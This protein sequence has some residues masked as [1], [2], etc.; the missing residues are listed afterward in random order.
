VCDSRDVLLDFGI[1]IVV[2]S[3]D[4]LLDSSGF[5]VMTSA[6]PDLVLYL[7]GDTNLVNFGI[8]SNYYNLT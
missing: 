7:H 6:E 2:D 5:L 8:N 3:R 1:V 4:F